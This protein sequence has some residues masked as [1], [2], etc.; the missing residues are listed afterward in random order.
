MFC[1]LSSSIAFVSIFATLDIAFLCLALGRRFPYLSSAVSGTY[2]PHVHLT[3]AGGV[4]GLLSAF[5]AWYNALAGIVENSNNRYV[6]FVC[7]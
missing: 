5:A 6:L 3:Y 7:F 2:E 1:T 4:F